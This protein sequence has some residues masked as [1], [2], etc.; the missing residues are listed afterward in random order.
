[1]HKSF[2]QFKRYPSGQGEGVQVPNSRSVVITHKRG[3]AQT[4]CNSRVDGT[5]R[6]KEGLVSQNAAP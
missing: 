6:I 1:M 5:V 4:W 2:I 3:N